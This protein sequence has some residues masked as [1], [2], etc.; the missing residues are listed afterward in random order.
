MLLFFQLR[1]SQPFFLRRVLCVKR[2][3]SPPFL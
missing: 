3:P 2:H 1:L